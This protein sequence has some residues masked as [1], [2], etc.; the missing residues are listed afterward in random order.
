[1][2]F[3]TDI[4]K[5][6]FKNILGSNVGH[7]LTVRN[8]YTPE[9]YT[10]TKNKQQIRE[11]LSLPTNK[12]IAMYT[13]KI[14]CG[15]KEISMLLESA[16]NLPHIQF[17]FVGG[18]EDVTTY[19]NE[20]S[21]TNNIMNSI[22]TGFVPPSDISAYQ[23]CADILL[24]YYPSDWPIAESVFPAK[25]LEYMATGNPIISVNF[26]TIGEVLIN[27]HN[28]ILIPPDNTT[29]L[30]RN[31]NELHG[32]S[33]KRKRLGECAKTTVS[34]YSWEERGLKISGLIEKISASKKSS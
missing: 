22:F 34:S 8:G 2:L 23:Y 14:S 16:K 17:V 10:F 29:L 33:E 13:G 21:R 25:L 20:Y 30:A 32:A 28:A 6:R 26:P 18:K 11:S 4:T 7:Y 19:W 9:A 12:T 5:N 24:I 15:S 31:I 3:T 27:E 1:M